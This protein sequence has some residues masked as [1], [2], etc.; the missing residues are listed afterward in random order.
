MFPSQFRQLLSNLRVEGQEKVGERTAW[1]VSGS[2]TWLPQVKLY[3]DR[4]TAYLL[5]LSYQQ[6]SHYCCHVFRIDYDDFYITNGIRI[7]M[8][9]TVNGPRESILEY[10]ID[11]VEVTPLDDARFARPAA[12]TAAR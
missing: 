9:W 6:K 7:P 11:T 2:S 12:A 5:S 10:E 3:F 1:V 8:E 4:D